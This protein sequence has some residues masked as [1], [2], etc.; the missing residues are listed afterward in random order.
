MSHQNTTGQSTSFLQ[1]KH[2]VEPDHTIGLRGFREGDGAKGTLELQRGG[3]EGQTARKALST[4]ELNL[5]ASEPISLQPETLPS[6][7]P[8]RSRA[9]S[10]HLI[11]GGPRVPGRRKAQGTQTLTAHV[12]QP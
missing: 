7:K 11:T 5:T 2:D 10:K 9:A 4:N 6:L 8:L 12:R 1:K 3:K